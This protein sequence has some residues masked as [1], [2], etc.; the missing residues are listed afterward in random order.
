MKQL[1]AEE[2]EKPFDGR[3]IRHIA[4]DEV[5]PNEIAKI[6]GEAIV[7]PELKWAVIPDEQ[8]LNNKLSVGMN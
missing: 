4:G 3:T 1:I 6:L 2:I 7:K 5:S 8:L